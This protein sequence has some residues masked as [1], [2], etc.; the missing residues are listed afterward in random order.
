VRE[1][2]IMSDLLNHYFCGVDTLKAIPEDISKNIDKG[3]FLLGSQG[4]DIFFYYNILPL[5]NAVPYGGIIHHE[6]INEFFYN[7]LKYMQEEKEEG[8]RVKLYSYLLG[9]TCHHGLDTNTHPFIINRSGKYK[10]GYGST[11]VYKNIH[12]K[13][14]VLLDVALLKHRYDIQANNYKI[15]NMFNLSNNDYVILDNLF[16]YLLD[17]TYNIEISD[18]HVA[19][20]AIKSEG[21]ILSALINPNGC[22]SIILKVINKFTSNN[23]YISTAVYPDSTDM[24]FI[25]NLNKDAWCHPCSK[26]EIY[27]LSYVELFEKAISDTYDRII[28]IENIKDEE[29]NID[30]INEIY[31]DLSY[32]TG[33]PCKDASEQRYFDINYIKRLRE[34]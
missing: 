14:E 31:S 29:F 28:K 9:F 17:K 19:Q 27:N 11:E 34:F 24:N 20:K 32:E 8:K 13:Y 6:K 16:K 12:K 21:R 22:E 5:R 25:L 10:K 2:V 3:L 23:G 26:K 1:G 15:K 33:L 18:Q 4:A 30:D 7:F